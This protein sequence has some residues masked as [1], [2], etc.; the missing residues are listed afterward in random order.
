MT[1]PLDPSRLPRLALDL[2]QAGRRFA[3]ATVLK[4]EGHTPVKAG[5][6][7]IMEADGTLHGTVGG[8]PV[9]AEAQRRAQAAMQSGRPEVFDFDLVGV[10][11]S[12]PLPICGGSMRVLID[13]TANQ[14]QAAFA[15]AAAALAARRRGVWVNRLHHTDVLKVTAEYVAGD[16]LS[17]TGGEGQGEGAQRD[18]MESEHAKLI[19]DG[20]TGEYFIAPLLPKPM[21]LVAGGG[22]VGQA[23]AT[24]ASLVGFELTILEDRPEF[25]EPTRF[26]AGTI[27]RCG[28]VAQEMAAFP[29][30][31]DTFIVLVTRGHRQDAEALAACIRRP[32]AY[33]G[34]IGSRRK[35]PLLR[36]QFL[37]S[38]WAT[39]EEFDRV[40]APIGLDIGAVT[41]SEIAAGVIA[42][43]ISVRRKGSAPRIPLQP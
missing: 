2:L 39:A 8:G 17:P 20:S 6:V 13:P 33:I 10:D 23:I 7:A 25:A 16:S 32:A 42:Q 40:Y 22:H 5:A 15:Q 36:Q 29:I 30:G 28:N 21:L 11:A 24:Q 3:V 18:C 34:M 43:L 9:E 19:S 31:R 26:P 27:T 14:H 1:S 4:A 37:A 41:V 12:E 35:V 38:G